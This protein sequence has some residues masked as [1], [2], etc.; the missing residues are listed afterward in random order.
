MGGK[1]VGYLG[2]GVPQEETARPVAEKAGTKKKKKASVRDARS[3]KL[4]L[5]L[6]EGSKQL[7]CFW[8][9]RP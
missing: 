9:D 1:V 3:Y 6:S 8:P 5:L 7:T 4:L 2:P